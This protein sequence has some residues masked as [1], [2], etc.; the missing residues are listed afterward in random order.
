MKRFL[1]LKPSE[2][3]KLNK[4][5][6]LNSIKSSE[7]RI[8]MT[9]S[10]VLKSPSDGI[11]GAEVAKSFGGDLI[12]LN[13]LDVFNPG[14]VG[15]DSKENP[16]KRLKELVSRP[17][18]LNLEPVDLNAN[19]MDE[20][21]KISEGR[22]ATKKSLMRA[23]ELGLDFVCFTGN[24]GTGVSNEK[25]IDAIKL[26]KEYFNGAIIA[27]K[28]HSSGIDEKIVSIDT[29]R[30][31]LDAG[32]DIILL[33]ALYTTPGTK[34]E[35]LRE[36]VEYIHERGKLALS[37]IGTSQESSS[38]DVINKI[39]LINKSIGFDIQHIG[40]SGYGGIANP[41]NILEISQA[42][43]GMRHT[44]SLIARSIRR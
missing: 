43:R 28:M 1:N 21:H 9:E 41:E 27:G 37:T 3:V 33:P 18:G 7:G 14:I 5:E 40:D 44:I 26:A 24:P 10:I 8:I 16:V 22:T 13:M 4:D 11:T 42:I 32:A 20:I 23:N 6:L 15:I 34:E 35:E 38:R 39:A 17:I 36:C 31:F 2:M 25:I 19:N 12:L 29:T 30:K